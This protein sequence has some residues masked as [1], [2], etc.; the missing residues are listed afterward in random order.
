MSESE[1]TALEEAFPAM[2]WQAFAKARQ[3]TLAAGI[4]VWES[5]GGIIYEVFPD[6]TKVERERIIP[7][8]YVPLGAKRVLR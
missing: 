1:I 2:A 4:S 7:P 3:E 8:T 6:G 5:E